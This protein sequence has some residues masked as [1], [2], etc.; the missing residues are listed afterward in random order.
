MNR[1]RIFLA[2]I[3]ALTLVLA[4]CGGGGEKGESAGGPTKITIWHGWTDVQADNFTRLLDQ[5]NKEHPDVQI[6]QLARRATRCC[7]KC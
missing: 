7:R 2:L 5:Y 4:A 3:A 6:T 1:S